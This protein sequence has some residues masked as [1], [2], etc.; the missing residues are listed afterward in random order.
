MPLGCTAVVWQKAVCNKIFDF[1]FFA[2]NASLGRKS[3][4]Q[5]AFM[6]IMWPEPRL[7]LTEG[8]VNPCNICKIDWQKEVSYKTDIFFGKYV[9][10]VSWDVTYFLL[11]DKKM[12]LGKFFL[13]SMLQCVFK[14][15][16][17]PFVRQMFRNK[18]TYFHGMRTIFYIYAFLTQGHI[19]NCLP[20][21]PFIKRFHLIDSLN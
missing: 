9:T 21:F 1:S 2:K 7:F 11:S 10:F 6:V 13:G 16:I 12:Q 5:L 8:K 20:K 4:V 3:N 18:V 15:N 19:I 14:C 17:L